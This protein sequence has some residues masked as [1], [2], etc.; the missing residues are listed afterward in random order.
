MT[1][2]G[3]NIQNEISGSLDAEATIYVKIGKSSIIIKGGW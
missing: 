3:S 2:Q 1:Y